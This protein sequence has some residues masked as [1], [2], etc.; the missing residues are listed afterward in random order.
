MALLD[1]GRNFDPFDRIR[2]SIPG[3]RKS[4]DIPGVARIVQDHP[5]QLLDRRIERGVEFNV[6]IVRPQRLLEFL[7]ADNLAMPSQQIAQ[8]AKRLGL[9]LEL[10]AALAQLPRR[11][12]SFIRTEANLVGRAANCSNGGI[13]FQGRP[14][15]RRGTSA[16]HRNVDP[17]SAWPEVLRS[18]AQF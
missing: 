8:E 10:G 4:L 1:P 5:A 17:A 6:R 12:V 9:N 3:P 2:K 15:S 14:G 11:Q 13:E 7:A 16:F 18:L